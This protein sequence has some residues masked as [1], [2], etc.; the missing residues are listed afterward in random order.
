[1]HHGDIVYL[2]LHQLEWH[3][4]DAALLL[5]YEVHLIYLIDNW[6]VRLV[7]IGAVVLLF[8]YA[9]ILY[10]HLLGVDAVT[11]RVLAR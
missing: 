1:M 11:A 7:M 6:C 8:T 3:H 10:G 5:S 2:L 4:L 9:W